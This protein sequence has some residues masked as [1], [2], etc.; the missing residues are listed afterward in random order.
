MEI[1]SLDNEKKVVR[2][3]TT[4]RSQMQCQPHTGNS[5]TDEQSGLDHLHLEGHQQE[6]IF[7]G[8][9]SPFPQRCSQ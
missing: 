9:E 8:A 5:Q 7:P 3:P 2:I 6:L 1:S 4:Q